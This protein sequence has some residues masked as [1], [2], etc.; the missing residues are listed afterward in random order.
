[1][2][3]G[4]ELENPINILGTTLQTRLVPFSTP[5]STEIINASKF[6][7]VKM[8]IVKLYDGTTDPEEHLG[9]YK[10]QTYIQDVDD[11]AYCR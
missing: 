7:K 10:A 6:D 3:V 9:V 1:V 11:T 5:F 8:A 2:E 4:R